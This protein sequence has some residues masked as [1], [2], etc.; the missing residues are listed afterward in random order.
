MATMITIVS[1]L[2]RSGTSMMMHMLGA[3]GVPLLIDSSRVADDDNPRGYYEYE[4][5]KHIANDDSWLANAEGKAVKMVSPLLE[6]LPATHTYT[7]IVMCRDMNE[8]V[9]SQ[10]AMLRRRQVTGATV[11]RDHLIDLCQRHLTATQRW[12]A[13]RQY[14]RVCRVD[15]SAVVADPVGHAKRVQQFLECPLD[16]DAMANVVDGSLYRQRKPTVS[17]AAVS[18]H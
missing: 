15:Y 3:G 13:K 14:C 11:T 16:I 18:L 4:P 12:L 9:D 5:V 10:T 17:I 8:V 7:I 2:P 6:H 1:G